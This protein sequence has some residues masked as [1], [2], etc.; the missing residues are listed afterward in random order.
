MILGVEIGGTKLQ[1]GVARSDLPDATLVVLERFSID[2][3]QGAQGILSQIKRHA[4]NLIKTHRVRGIGI[5]FG[6][7]VDVSRQRVIK[8]HQVEGW[9]DFPLGEWCERE[10]GLPAFLGN[11]CNVAALAEAVHGAGRGA[12][13]VFYVTI[14]TGIGGGMVVAGRIDGESC[15]AVAEVGHLRPGLNATDSH[16][17]VESVASGLGMEQ[18]VMRMLASDSARNSDLDQLRALK[19]VTARDIVAASLAGNSIANEIFAAAI[20]TLGWAL[21][22]VI[23]I[24][25]PQRIVVGGGVSLIGD[26]LFDRLR[27]A[28]LQYVFPPLAEHFQLMPAALGEETVVVGALELAKRY[29][30]EA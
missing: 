1:F 8:S 22:Q 24:A 19:R 16:A 12:E 29:S 11:D 28:V 2:R 18:R 6:G 25:A 17:T 15:P 10:L 20:Q 3:D 9:D 27:E 30:P 14:G 26:P 5:G 21:A 7:P 4:P 13:R 23:T